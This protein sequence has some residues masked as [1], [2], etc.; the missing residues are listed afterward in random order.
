M[1]IKLLEDHERNDTCLGIEWENM[2]SRIKMIS[3]RNEPLGD[4]VGIW[5]G[6][7]YQQISG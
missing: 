3:R 2:R 1:V 5:V 4:G 7:E 6:L